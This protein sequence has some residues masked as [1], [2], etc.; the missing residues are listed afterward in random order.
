VLT[1]NKVADYQNC[2]LAF[3]VEEALQMIQN[4]PK[5]FVIG[6]ATI[7]RLMLQYADELCI[8]HILADFEADAFFPEIKPETWQLTEEIFDS[9]DEK[10]KYDIV[11]QQYV[12]IK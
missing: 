2:E 7:Y 9:K 11:Y 10:N 5:V 8:T 4:E 3:S 12:R 6:G 1:L